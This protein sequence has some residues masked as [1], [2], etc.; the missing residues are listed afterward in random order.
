MVKLADL[1]SDHSGIGFITPWEGD[2]QNKQM[3]IEFKHN[4]AQID[5]DNYI[6][7][8]LTFEI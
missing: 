7:L 2:S 8:T 4:C 6:I 5:N 1:K 3:R